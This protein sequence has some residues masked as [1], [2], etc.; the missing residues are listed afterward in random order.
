MACFSSVG[1]DDKSLVD[2]EVEYGGG[3][4]GG[5]GA[6]PCKV[7]EEESLLVANS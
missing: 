4:G 3:G 7:L 2:R 5:G 6:S 1:D